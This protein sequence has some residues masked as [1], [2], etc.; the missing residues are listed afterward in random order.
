LLRL[1]PSRNAMSEVGGIVIPLNNNMFFYHRLFQ[2]VPIINLI[3]LKWNSQI[4]MI[5]NF[6]EWEFHETLCNDIGR[7]LST[8]EQ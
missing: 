5:D 1:V 3:A 2:N 6:L 7:A 8:W 4:I